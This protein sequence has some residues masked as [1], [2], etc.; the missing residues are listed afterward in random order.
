MTNLQ[1]VQKDMS[2]QEVEAIAGSP[3]SRD[4]DIWSNHLYFRYGGDRVYFNHDEKV[5]Y[6]YMKDD[7]D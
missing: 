3:D 4:R 5:S 2:A 7:N 6:T 1:Q